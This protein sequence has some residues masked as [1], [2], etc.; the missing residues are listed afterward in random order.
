[1]CVGEVHDVLVHEHVVT[2]ECSLRYI[3][4]RMASVFQ[5]RT[6]YFMFLN[7]PP[8]NVHCQQMYR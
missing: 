5:N 6:L 2:K 8:T 7:R 1:M 4:I 3:R